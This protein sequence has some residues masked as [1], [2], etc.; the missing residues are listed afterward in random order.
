M[1]LQSASCVGAQISEA[2]GKRKRKSEQR[3]QQVGGSVGNFHVGGQRQS[4]CHN[5]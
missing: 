2:R 4:L 5:G 1:R 3:R